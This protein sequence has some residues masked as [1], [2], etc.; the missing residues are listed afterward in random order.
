MKKSDKI[1]E[2]LLKSARQVK[3]ADLSETPFGFS[4]R[5]VAEWHASRTKSSFG[6][7]FQLLSLRVFSMAACI[8]CASLIFYWQ[9]GSSE[10]SVAQD[11]L[12]NP[13]ALTLESFL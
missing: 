2:S 10:L 6:D 1:L 11:F 4:T 9:A 8:A 13:S 3:Q 7:M 5:V 12:I